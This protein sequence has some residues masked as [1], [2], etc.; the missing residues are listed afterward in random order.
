MLCNTL[1]REKS[2]LRLP[3][4]QD[5]ANFSYNKQQTITQ[6]QNSIPSTGNWFFIWVVGHK[7]ASRQSP[8][9]CHLLHKQATT[10]SCRRFCIQRRATC[11]QHFQNFPPLLSP[12]S[13]AGVFP[14]CGHSLRHHWKAPK[15][16]HSS[17]AAW[18][19]KSHHYCCHQKSTR[20]ANCI[21]PSLNSWS[22]I[23]LCP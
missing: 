1:K 17:Y 11:T 16:M 9:T 12:P 13:R 4:L 22:K 14:P 6:E 19:L 3:L 7:S 21:L 20:E 18:P 8:G 15:T 23:W 10:E 2:K 5:F